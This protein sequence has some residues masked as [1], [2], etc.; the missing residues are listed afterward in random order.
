MGPYS[1]P[2]PDHERAGVLIAAGPRLARRGERGT[3]SILDVAPTVL[4][5]LGLPVHSE[6]QGRALTD[7][8]RDPTP[9]RVVPE[10]DDPGFDQ[11]TAHLDQPFTPTEL[12]ELEE[13]LRALGY[14]GES[15]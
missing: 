8:L 1:A 10:A 5:L 15:P 2:V 11:G 12:R 7:L 3:A 6:M 9:P 4:H 13:R 14:L